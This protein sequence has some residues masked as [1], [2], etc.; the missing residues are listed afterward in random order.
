[1]EA[2]LESCVASAE[3]FPAIRLYGFAPACLSLGFS[4]EFARA[5]D[6]PYCRASGIDV[7]RRPTGGRAVLHDVEVT[8]SVVARRDAPPFDGSL[9][10][11]YD[12]ISLGLLAAFSRL[13][14]SARIASEAA[15][16]AS[17]A[18]RTV[19]FAEPSRHEIVVGGRKVAGSSQTRRRN[20]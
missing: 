19:C 12:A 11:V 6:A 10:E 1:D 14:L 5:V 7:V 16:N 2:L 13:G 4:Q 18:T 20:A 3:G 9:L 15:S 8:Y 17:P